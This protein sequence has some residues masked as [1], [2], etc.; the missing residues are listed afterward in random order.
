MRFL[1][2]DYL[3]P[4]DQKPIKEGVVIVDKS[5]K[6]ISVIDSRKKVPTNK[7]EVFEGIISPGFINAHCHLEL[8]Y[9]QNKI[10]KQVG[11]VD[12]IKELQLKKI[13]NENI[14][15]AIEYA[16]NLM[17]KNGIVGVGDICN[18]DYTLK[19][20]VK[21]NLKYYNFIELYAVKTNQV[22]KC[23]N[24]A[25]C[26]KKKFVKHNLQSTIV[27]HST[28][29]VHPRLMHMILNYMQEND[30]ISIH[31]LETESERDY[32]QKKE[33]NIFK[34]L[35]QLD[36]DLS[37][38]SEKPNSYELINNF[39]KQTIFVHN[40]FAKKIEVENKLCCTCPNANLFI[41]GVLP[42][43]DK[44][45]KDTLCVGTDSLASNENLSILEEL[46]IIQNNSTYC[47]NTLLKIGCLNG[48]KA[49]KFNT[50]GSIFEGKSPGLNLITNIKNLKL[51]NESI[52][53]PLL[54]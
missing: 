47:L 14:Y 51:T 19:Q 31:N 49:L 8:S 1:T 23:F 21:K 16:E 43:Y 10:S 17:I 15:E 22:E 32:L 35:K 3:F 45:D 18:T 39:N 26:L 46:L 7:L 11:L 41:E 37:I 6:I 33:G 4:L 28:Y 13:N 50:L 42:S 24:D 5:G 44:F 27:P 2:A 48:A 30:L 54:N 40:T 34:W 38:W 29:G 36:A 12:F 9:L 20:K 52:V 25:K 53:K